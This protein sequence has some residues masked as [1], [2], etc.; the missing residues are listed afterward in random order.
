MY[1][2]VLGAIVGAIQGEF[3]RLGRYSLAERVEYSVRYANKYTVRGDIAT[4]QCRNDCVLG[5][6][7]EIELPRRVRSPPDVLDLRPTT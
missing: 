1:A 7:F 4:L 6:A 2:G 3:D 5:N